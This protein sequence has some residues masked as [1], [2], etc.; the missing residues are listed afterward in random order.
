MPRNPEGSVHEA[1]T[2]RSDT[3]TLAERNLLGRYRNQGILRFKDANA[4]YCLACQECYGIYCPNCKIKSATYHQPTGEKIFLAQHGK[5][6]FFDG[7]YWMKVT[8]QKC[9]YLFRVIVR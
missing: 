1:P 4:F 3:F 9:D 8:C 2:N 5:A 6:D 7:F